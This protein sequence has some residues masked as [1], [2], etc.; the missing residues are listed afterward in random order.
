MNFNKFASIYS[1][2]C[3]INFSIF[4]ALWCVSLTANL[5]ISDNRNFYVLISYDRRHN[6]FVL[7]VFN[8][9]FAINFGPW[10]V[11]FIFGMQYSFK[12]LLDDTKVNDLVT[13]TLNFM[14]VCSNFVAARGKVFHKH[15]YIPLTFS[16]LY[17]LISVPK[18]PLIL[19]SIPINLWWCYILFS[20]R[21]CSKF[22]LDGL[23]FYKLH[24]HK[25]W[26]QISVRA[27][28]LFDKDWNRKKEWL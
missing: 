14:K 4:S 2:K 16:V 23:V 3:M 17:K 26:N 11:E 12:A 19:I 10:E 25:D 28:M 5:V 22:K 24:S 20:K 21:T 7:S 8:F 1:P 13:L 15:I 27:N 6:V 18:H 9:N